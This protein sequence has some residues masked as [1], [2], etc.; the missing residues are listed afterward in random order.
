MAV[1][2]F[3]YVK[4]YE[5][6]DPIL[7]NVYVVFRLDGHG[8]HRFSDIHWFAKPND[9][10]ALELMDR[11]ARDVMDAYPDIVLG[12]GESDE[13]SFLL[14]RSCTLY[15][16]RQSKIL[17]TLTSHFTSCYV[18]HWPTYFPETPLAYPP[19]FDGRLVVYPTQTEVR[20][21]FS[22]RQS[23][24]HVNNLYNT[25]FW[26]L[27]QQGGMST[28]EAHEKL[29]GTVSSAKNEILFTEFGINY[30]K[31]PTRFRKGSTLVREE[32]VVAPLPTET[33][34]REPSTNLNDDE[35]PPAVPEVEAD[36]SVQGL[37]PVGQPTESVPREEE[38]KPPK[39]GKKKSRKAKKVSVVK[40]L[41]C[42]IIGKEFWE[43]REDILA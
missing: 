25:V 8:F 7:P 14:R 16:R 39:T 24:T 20:D 2:R 27:V 23:D 36:T 12:F 17:S 33:M 18:F 29:R 34:I 32:E 42:D 1:S 22:W 6:P 30:N 28:T 41:H 40:V 11:A 4:S 38:G 9:E 31:L 35:L 15:S 21:Y 3:A 19:S 10:R 43:R 37:D 26:A 5:L 13:F